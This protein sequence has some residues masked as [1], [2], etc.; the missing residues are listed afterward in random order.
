MWMIFK[1]QTQDMISATFWP[2][3]SLSAEVI[4]VLQLPP[5]SQRRERRHVCPLQSGFF[6]VIEVWHPRTGSPGEPDAIL[7]TFTGQLVGVGSW[8]MPGGLYLP[9]Q[10]VAVGLTALGVRSDAAYWN[11]PCFRHVRGC[12]FGWRVG[13]WLES[14]FRGAIWRRWRRRLARSCRGWGGRWEVQKL[15]Q[16]P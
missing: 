2:E 5:K 4:L 6:Q 13:K 3:V 16:R 12:C 1:K 7:P 9:R 8:G 11:G 10:R 14:Q 15:T